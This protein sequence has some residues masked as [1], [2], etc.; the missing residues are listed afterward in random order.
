MKSIRLKLAKNGEGLFKAV[1]MLG[2][3]AQGTVYQGKLMGKLYAV[4][5]YNGEDKNSVEAQRRARKIGEIIPKPRTGALLR[6]WMVDNGTDRE[7]NPVMVFQLF[8]NPPLED[9]YNS[10]RP[11]KDLRGRERIAIGL[12][13]GLVEIHSNN[14]VHSDL[15]PLNILYSK[16]GE[17]AIID[18]DGAG[19]Y[20][21]NGKMLPPIV[22]GHVQFPDWPVPQEI[23]S[24]NLNYGSDVWWL[25]SLIIKA[26]TG[27]TPFFFLKVADHNSIN[28]LLD[29]LGN[30]QDVWPPRFEILSKHSKVQPNLSKTQL[31]KVRMILN[32]TIATS[33]LAKIFANYHNPEMR[34]NAK[35]IWASFRPRCFR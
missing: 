25:G 4:K 19:Y 28:E 35:Q 21:K 26:L 5:I 10:Y 33:I 30:E 12:T 1:S 27:Y 31:D 6:T 17:V 29:L 2:Q 20:P 3:G 16:R 13:A 11:P 32:Q 18:F 15:A 23:K 8:D 22:Q 34:P 14:I 24:N 9:Y 7:G